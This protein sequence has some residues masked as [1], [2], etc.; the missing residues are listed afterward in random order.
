LNQTRQNIIQTAIRLFNERGV[1]KV[2]IRDIADEIGI[3]AGNVTYHYKTKQAL[4]DSV[5]RFMIKKLEEMS[6]G[7]Q[8]MNPDKNQLQVAKG[9]LEH[10]THFGFFYQDTLEIIRSYPNL[11]DLHKQQVQQE[12]S[13]I[14][15]LI[16]LSVGKGDLVAEPYE[17]MYESLAHS[18]WMTLHFWL[19]QQIIRGEKQN[20]LEMGLVTIA[21]L[22]YPFVTEKGK[23][24]FKKM[25]TE[26][27]AMAI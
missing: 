22:T 4:M 14:R 3:S 19:T 24:I 25:R 6:I 21:N 10:I 23:E 9:Y 12:K 2:R 17:G 27:L 7:N 11:A 8:L 15:N 18:I 16:F 13:I 20:N 1:N 26:L 5:Y